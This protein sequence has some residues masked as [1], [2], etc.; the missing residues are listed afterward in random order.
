MADNNLRPVN[1][2]LL[3]PEAPKDTY[4]SFSH[5]LRMIGKKANTPPLGLLT[6]AGMLPRDRFALRL[7]DMNIEALADADIEWADYV[8]VSSMIAHKNCLGGVLRRLKAA[9]KTVI[10][11]GPYTSTAY[12]ETANVD[13]FVIGEAEAVWDAFLADL[14]AGRLRPAYA[15]P[16]REEEAAALRSHFGGD[17]FI[18]VAADHPDINLAPLPRYD[19]LKMNQYAL[20]PVQASRGCPVGCE[21]CDIWRRYGRKPRNKTHSRLIAEL[22]EIYRLG[23]RDTVFLVDD[24]FIGNKVRAKEILR[25][26]AAWQRRKGWPFPFLTEATLSI[27]DDDE[28]LELMAGAGFL[29]VFVGIETPVHESLR[30]T[31][32]HINT[33]GSIAEKVAKIQRHGIQIMSGFIIGFD[34]DPDDIAQRMTDCIQELGIPQAMVGLLTA[35]PDTDLHERLE[36]EG[37]IKGATSG[38]NTHDFAVNFVTARPEERVIEDYKRVLDAAYS[39]TL[40]GYFK[41]CAVLRGRWP[42]RRAHALGRMSLSFQI[43]A[44]TGYLWTALRSPYR[45]NAYRFLLTTLLKK[46]GFFAEAVTLG[47]KGH[48]LWAITRKAF[49]V[50][51]MREFMVERLQGYK[52]FLQG[53][54]ATLGELVAKAGAQVGAAGV[55]L[56]A[57][58]DAVLKSA[59]VVDASEELRGLYR[60]AEEIAREVEQYRRRIQAEA[61][62]KFDRL[63]RDAKKALARELDVFMAEA[64][65]LCRGLRLEAV[66]A[67]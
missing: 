3:Y 39:R 4:W 17:A 55:D 20:M 27:A 65:S 41:R 26:A 42:G 13:C 63:S 40:S 23:W 59:A 56:G 24:N 61:E 32:K 22:D 44:L 66:A 14:S 62:L 54:R 43:Q 33:T 30:E 7:V 35:L 67:V 51:G 2:L 12:R 15:S 9:D 6:V 48:H 21:F 64:D 50:E 16:V 36:R 5:A 47:V 52:A 60:R 10:A 25:E 57:A 53:R 46:P 28:L 49:E 19:L 31:R 11:G 1:V 34:A 58:M 45:W 29:S 18:A 38:N 8:F 37:R